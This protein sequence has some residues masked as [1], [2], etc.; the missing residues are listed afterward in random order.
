MLQRVWL[1]EKAEE[2]W[3]PYWN[4]WT[5]GEGNPEMSFAGSFAEFLASLNPLPL[6]Y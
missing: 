2:K 3:E 5:L 6:V 4:E 1:G